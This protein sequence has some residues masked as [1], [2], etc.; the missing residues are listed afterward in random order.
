MRNLVKHGDGY[1]NLEEVSK[2]DLVEQQVTGLYRDLY[3]EKR[4]VLYYLYYKGETSPKISI[5]KKDAPDAFYIIEDWI[6]AHTIRPRQRPVTAE[7]AESEDDG[8]SALVDRLLA[9]LEEE[10]YE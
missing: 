3:G 8:G 6:K 5:N 1:I 4:Q 10:D 9:D 7:D 2:F